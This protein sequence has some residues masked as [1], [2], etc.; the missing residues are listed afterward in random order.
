[1]AC[2]YTDDVPS[3]IDVPML[4]EDMSEDEFDG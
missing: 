4:G 3:C 1:M 2:R